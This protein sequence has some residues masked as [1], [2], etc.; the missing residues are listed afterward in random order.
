MGLH[1]GH[2]HDHGHTHGKGA[3]KKALLISLCITTTFLI[4]EVIGGFLTNSLAL[5]SDAG[6]M[7]S[8]SSA[9]FLSLIA[10]YF[11]S[12]PP[13]PAKTY[14]FYRFEILAALINGVTLVL[15]SLYIFWEAIERL[16]APPEVSSL[17]MMGI[18]FVGLLANI[19]A[20][21]VLMRGDYK[22]NLNMRSAFL[23][24]LGD[25]LGSVGAIAAGFLMWMFGWYIADPIISI[26]VGVLIMI[27]AWR[28]TKE[29]VN[30]LM[31]GTPSSIDT[32]KVSE[33]LEMIEGVTHVH[34][35]HIW[36]VTS[37]FDSLT[38]HLEVKD[39]LPSY[40]VL[41][42]ALQVLRDQFGITHATVQIENSAV[43]HD[44][45]MC[46]IGPGHGHDHTHDH[47]HNHN[48]D[49]EHDHSHHKHGQH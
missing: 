33:T 41:Q 29:S 23:H 14:G 25:M 39:D 38:V 42:E 20:A 17:S 43:R 12:K 27:S 36:T 9:L 22:N 48:H 31:E 5:L 11:A 40:P 3:N 21:F 4:I 30:V 28:V 7:L 45:M 26:V 47:D 37:G 32:K 35:L 34:D 13:S 10:M 2:S 6:H 1:H 16:A 24:V 8:D 46:Q 19:A 18:A 15:I 44:E 49:H